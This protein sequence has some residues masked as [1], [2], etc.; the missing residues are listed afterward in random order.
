ME[1]EEIISIVLKDVNFY[2]NSGGG[3]TLSGGEPLM[4]FDFSKELLKKAKQNNINTVIETCGYAKWENIFE[5]S[6]YVDIFYWDIKETNDLL[7]KKYTGVSNKL[8]LDNL[9]KLDSIGSHIVLRCPIIPG[10]NDREEHF[11]EIGKLA[12]ELINVMEVQIMP[13]HPLGKDKCQQIGEDYLMGELTFQDETLINRWLTILRG[14]T[15][16]PVRKG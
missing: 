7:H 2:N 15:S 6:K 13:F 8:I 3:L 14:F 11:K 10:Y 5:L 16:K 12:N 9:Y 4:N 1:I